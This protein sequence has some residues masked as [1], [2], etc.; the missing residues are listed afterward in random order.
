[1]RHYIYK[2]SEIVEVLW[3]QDVDLGYSLTP[4]QLADA[5]TSAKALQS[6]NANDDDIEKL[7]A[8]EALKLDNSKY[9]PKDIDDNDDDNHLGDEWAGIPFTI[10]NETGKFFVKFYLYF[11]NI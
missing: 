4:A 9:D 1:M 3:K 10:D 2:E 6:S 5:G 8:L 11:I 7:K